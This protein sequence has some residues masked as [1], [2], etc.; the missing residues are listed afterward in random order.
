MKRLVKFD[1]ALASVFSGRDRHLL[2]DFNFMNGGRPPSVRK[3]AEDLGFEIEERSLPRSVSGF[4]EPAMTA[5]KGFRIVVNKWQSVVRR[6]WTV[7]HE[8]A[9]YYL[10]PQHTELFAREAHRADVAGIG[11]FYLEDELEEEREADHWVEAIV[12]DQKALETSVARYGS[13]LEA[14]AKVFGVSTRT[15]R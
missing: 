5:D 9:H 15:A 7:L 13:D 8:I 11:H 2:R 10:H 4:L 14:I 1:D 3:L 6:R 12:F